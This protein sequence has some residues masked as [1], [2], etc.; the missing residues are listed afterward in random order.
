[1]REMS[2]ESALDILEG[3]KCKYA[4]LH[5]PTSEAAMSVAI[6][7]IIDKMESDDKSN[8]QPELDEWCEDCK[9]YDQEQHCC[10][11]FNRVIRTAMQDAQP[12]II[13]CKDCK[14]W[15]LNYY[16]DVETCFEHRNVDGTEQATRAEDYCSWAE[17][18]TDEAD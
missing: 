8:A 12:E 13:K 14:H 2:L 16:E 1:M 9:E 18:R 4:Q 15:R 10:S 17:R 6:Q 3:Y 7:A 11:R 5:Y